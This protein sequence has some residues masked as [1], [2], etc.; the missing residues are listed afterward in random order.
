MTH[1]SIFA[2]LLIMKEKKMSTIKRASRLFGFLKPHKLEFSIG[3]IFLLLS[4]LTSLI[5][6]ALMGNLVDAANESVVNNINQIALWLLLLFALQAV[7][8][9]FRIV[10]FVNVTEKTLAVLRQQ[11]Y[12]HLIMLP[13]PFLS[14]KRVGELN[15]RIAAD[16]ALLQETFTT[17]IA[18][19]I[20]Q[21]LIIIGGIIFLSVTSVKLTLFMLALVPVMMLAA[22]FFGRYI[23]RFSKEVQQK[24][25]E[26]NTIIE[27]TLQGIAN[28]K[29]FTNEFFE[30]NRYKEK[31]NQ[32]KNIAQKGGRYRGAFASFIIFCLF[33]SI[34]AVIWFGVLMINSGQLS[35]GQLFTFVLYSVFIGSS[36]GG[37]ADIYSKLQKAI[38]STEHLLDI[39]EEEK[40]V[41]GNNTNL[42]NEIKEGEIHFQNLSFS[43]PSR[44]NI[45]VID[46]LSFII[47]KG[48]FIA[49]V[50]PSG[51]GKTTIAS[52]L[53]GFYKIEKGQLVIDN[54][55]IN[56][57]DLHH[58]RQQIAL[59]P[60]DVILFGG[61]IKE[62]IA[63]GNLQA[64]DKEIEQAA[65]N[66][67]AYDF[68][69]EFP[70]K[71]DTLVG[72]RGIQLSGG[73]RQRIAIARALLKN[74]KILIMDEATSALDS[75]SEKLVQQ[76]MG[77]LMIGRTTI[78]IAHRLSTIKK[79]DCILVIDKGRIVEQGNHH[80]L[81]K[82]QGLYNHLSQLQ[83]NP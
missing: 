27:E 17:D 30:I 52:L 62:N 72:E 35:I 4:T 59:V 32:V 74:P 39:L 78:V 65:I 50:G 40:E 67:N 8:S 83:F 34:V 76:A 63:Y 82:K 37:M 77:R 20:R 49:I 58:L 44:P 29:A 13:M 70:E 64:S 11:T 54:N 6:P 19:F 75:E 79:A 3:L 66:A 38:G 41:I 16:I 12:A 1:N 9:Y 36:V 68:I 25:A 81:E 56:D 55:D 21:V 48:Q 71:M 15:S 43:Y 42:N 60:Q 28:V 26:S 47:K 18:E 33:G 24:V 51:A 73:Q 57:Y 2:S 69:N 80:E 22:V 61:S 5:F 53:L 46:H 14:K 7:F 23:K 10:I 45:T 31:T